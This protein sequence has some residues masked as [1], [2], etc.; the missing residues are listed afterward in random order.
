[1]KQPSVKSRPYNLRGFIL[2][3]VLLA[4]TVVGAIAYL[5]NREGAMNV[6]MALGE[7]EAIKARYVAEAG[8]AYATAQMNSAGTCVAPSTPITG[9]IGSDVFSVTASAVAG[10]P[11]QVTLTST[12]TLS[13]KP[14]GAPIVKTVPLFT[15]LTG[16]VDIVRSSIPQTV[17]DTFLSNAAPNLS[18]GNASTGGPTAN[19]GSDTELIVDNG[20]KGG[21]ILI[22][23]GLSTNPMPTGARL[24]SAQL[25]LTLNS[26]NNTYSL[27]TTKPRQISDVTVHKITTPWE[28]GTGTIANPSTTSG[29]SY[30]N[31]NATA[32][33][34]SNWESFSDSR[35]FIP[36]T[37]PAPLSNAGNMATNGNGDYDPAWVS[38]AQVDSYNTNINGNSA[39][40]ASMNAASNLIHTWDITTLVAEWLSGADNYGVDSGVLL[41]AEEALGRASFFSSEEG[42]Q[43]RRPTLTLNYKIPCQGP[44]V[45]LAFKESILLAGNPVPGNV[46]ST[47]RTSAAGVLNPA[48]L[49][50]TLSNPTGSITGLTTGM[51]I[52]FT[53]MFDPQFSTTV[54][55]PTGITV[56]T[57]V[58]ATNP[59]VKSLTGCGAMVFNPVAGASSIL[60]S[61]GS[62]PAAA[63]N[64]P[65]KCVVTVQVVFGMVSGKVP[66]TYPNP[67]Y[68]N[69]TSTSLFIKAGDLQTSAGNNLQSA[70]TSIFVSPGVFADTYLDNLNGTNATTNFGGMAYMSLQNNKPRNALIQFTNLGL[71][72]TTI[73]K[74]AKLRL[75]ITQFI[76]PRTPLTDLT[77]SISP[78]TISWIESEATWQRRA[79]TPSN[80]NWN[81]AGAI[82]SDITT[83]NATTVILPKTFLAPGWIEIPIPVAAVN[84]WVTTPLN[85]FGLHLQVTTSTSSGSDEIQIASKESV[86]NVPQLV[87]T[88]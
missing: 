50:I 20:G 83:V 80:I 85:N 15:N 2:I 49:E 60:L 26:A 61:G 81:K 58:P 31:R 53:K 62:I 8:L 46:I 23:F 67:L 4:L 21:S 73:I 59:V 7:A 47:A 68:P 88:Y 63:A 79:T 52:D 13:G 41:R 70:S 43:A 37:V 34:A 25:K 10:T 42:N 77:I 74:S 11:V 40:L 54:A 16:S 9:N 33:S 35:K 18:N 22:K 76:A 86:A 17:S 3:A 30:N 48:F 87:I 55:T 19:Y 5:L 14:A 45:A 65:G 27:V 39:V 84:A 28:E 78:L 44:S 82:G 36:Y 12:P 69:G 1:M 66:G 24:T 71:P 75:Y 57:P 72:A 6:E 38:V 64:V 51:T 32:T 29:A 56:A